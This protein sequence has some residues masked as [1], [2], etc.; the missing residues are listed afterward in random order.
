M[1]QFWMS[2]AGDGTVYS[3]AAWHTVQ[4]SS[5]LHKC[6][7]FTEQANIYW[8]FKK[9]YKLHIKSAVISM[10]KLWFWEM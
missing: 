1:C 2:G 4:Y 10:R 6:K 5:F 8:M 3:S 7:E 9:A